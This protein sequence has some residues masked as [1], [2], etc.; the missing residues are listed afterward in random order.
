MKLLDSV[1][2][3]NIMRKYTVTVPITVYV[4]VEVTSDNI[5]DAYGEVTDSVALSCIGDGLIKV[6][7][8]GAAVAVGTI[9]FD[10]V[11]IWR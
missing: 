7:P 11:D 6:N 10:N 3:G 1:N 4:T 5:E 9:D 8:Q 2:R